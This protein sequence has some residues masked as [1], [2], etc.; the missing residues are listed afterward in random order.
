VQDGFIDGVFMECSLSLMNADLALAEA[1]RVLKPGGMLVVSDIYF[2]NVLHHEQA[3]LPT[4]SCLPGVSAREA[5]LTK[6]I[7]RGFTIAFWQD[8]SEL[9]RAL[10]FETIMRYGSAKELWRRLFP[11]AEQLCAMREQVKRLR[12]GYFLLIAAKDLSPLQYGCMDEKDAGTG[13]ITAKER[14]NCDGRCCAPA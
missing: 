4:C 10:L 5:I 6:L 3:P 9:I 13:N 2:R 8:Q 7:E 12:P 14:Q 1:N 11:N